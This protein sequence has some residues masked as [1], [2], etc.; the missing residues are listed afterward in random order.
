MQI[1]LS[2]KKASHIVCASLLVVPLVILRCGRH[3]LFGW[4]LSALKVNHR[5]LGTIGA[6]LLGKT[7]GGT[8]ILEYMV[9]RT[10]ANDQPK[11]QSM[12][13][14]LKGPLHYKRATAHQKQVMPNA[15]KSPVQMARQAMFLRGWG[16]FLI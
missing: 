1:T 15:R 11:V 14:E 12:T 7:D 8:V 5:H 4:E 10:R 13:Y 16:Q 9:S 2:A 3:S 6:Y